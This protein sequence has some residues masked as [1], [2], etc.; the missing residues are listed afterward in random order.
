MKLFGG[1]FY[2]FAAKYTGR[3]SDASR[4]ARFPRAGRHGD[5]RPDA[6]RADRIVAEPR[7]RVRARGGRRGAPA[8]H[9]AGRP[10]AP[11][12]NAAGRGHGRIGFVTGALVSMTS[13]GSG[14]LL[15]CV[16]ALAYPLRARETVGTDL[17][18]ALGLSAAATL[19]HA[20]AGRVDFALAGAVL[21]GAIP[22]VLT[23]A[24]LATGV[25]EESLRAALAVVLVAIGVR[26]R[27]S[28]SCSRALARPAYRRNCDL[29]RCAGL[30]S[31]RAR[32]DARTLRRRARG[33]PAADV[34]RWAGE[35]YAPRLTLAS[36]FGAEGCVLIDLIG[37]RGCRSIC[38]RSI[39]GSSSKRPTHSGAV[40]SSATTLR[41][42]A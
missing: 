42:A 26:W 38:S 17:V 29:R 21:A 25:Q 22:G 14:S 32:R 36:G 31:G 10:A 16:L 15:L 7:P 11:A 18:H 34:L 35:R 23:G 13:V 37:R 5:P 27:F 1:G 3:P 6:G 40:W 8:A 28:A 30:Q 39:P 33:R 41:F 20:S 4:S 19:G 12:A 2:A 9:D 24:R